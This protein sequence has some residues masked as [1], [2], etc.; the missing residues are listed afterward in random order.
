MSKN[1][2]YVLLPM[3]LWMEDPEIARLP[4]KEWR[5]FV[6]S[7]IEKAPVHYEHYVH[8]TR[9]EYEKNREKIR[10][11]IIKRDG[12]KCKICGSR[13]QLEI[14]HI[15]PIAMGGTNDLNNLQV[16]CRH[17]NRSKGARI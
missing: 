13:R 1:K 16:L 11:T 10:K 3:G 6:E 9:K 17:C 12:K 8:P 5:K 14:D 4:D 2:P 15:N 7:Y